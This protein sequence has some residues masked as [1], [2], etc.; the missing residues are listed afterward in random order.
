MET[1][2]SKLDDSRSTL[3]EVVQTIQTNAQTVADKKLKEQSKKE[4]KLET[5]KLRQI[6]RD[7]YEELFGDHN[8][9]D[10]TSRD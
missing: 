9:N 5:K 6:L 1:K 7:N 3:S 8:E 10:F 2:P 4:K